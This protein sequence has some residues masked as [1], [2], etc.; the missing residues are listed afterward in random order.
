[1]IAALVFAAD[2]GT[3]L[4]LL[5]R[6]EVRYRVTQQIAAPTLAGGIGIP[7]DMGV[8][9]L[10]QP[11]A[12]L[13]LAERRWTFSAEYSPL[14]LAPDL[15]LGFS[16]ILLNVASTSF[17]WHDRFVRVTLGQDGTYGLE[18]SAYLV[19]DQT[20]TGQTPTIQPVAAPATITF[21]ASH[22]YGGLEVRLGRHVRVTVGAEYL[23]AG[24]LDAY[25]QQVLPLESG[26]RATARIAYDATRRDTLSASIS[27]QRDEFST[28]LCIEPL[29][30]SYFPPHGGFC[31]PQSD[32]AEARLQLAHKL[33]HSATASV[34]GGIA[35]TD[36]RTE[37]D[38]PYLRSSYGLADAQVIQTFG[39]HGT[40][41]VGF[42]ALLAPY[43]DVRTGLV[44][45]AASVDLS[46]VDRLTSL[47]TVKAD[48]G[49]SQTLS[50][51]YAPQ[52]TIV[53]AN[54]A[55][56]LSVSK[57]VQFEVGERALWQRQDYFG[58]FVTAFTYCA[59]TVRERKLHF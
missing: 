49:G 50:S 46:L 45:D 18:N 40:S 12:H 15:E 8:D 7:S 19:A 4:E 32:L 30:Q 57:Q 39:Q 37:T 3:T 5:D 10:N 16:P 41:N 35:L 26:P 20:L 28:S 27:G 42:T 2:T 44:T 34:G 25:A 47:V 54:A 53:Q 43:V 31:S 22:T 58:T 56:D 55:V 38:A 33:S 23:V 29:G 1:M 48:S 6:S 51:G 24:G 11:T 17:A 59:V 52:A 36:E 14:F 21:G 13:Q 9:I